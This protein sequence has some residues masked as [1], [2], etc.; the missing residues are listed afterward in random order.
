MNTLQDEV[1]S[2]IIWING[3]FGA[4]KTTTAYELHKRLPHSTV[5]DPER[6]GYV[7]MANIPKD[8]SK[9]DF[10]DYPLWREANFQLLKQIRSEEHTSELQSR[11]HLVC[12]L[13]LEKKKNEKTN[14]F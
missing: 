12:R 6:F 2:M 11:G 13:L 10:Q 4:G 7:L 5:Y 1:I 14:I 8:I 3:T 9:G